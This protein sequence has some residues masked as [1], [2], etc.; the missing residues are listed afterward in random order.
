MYS[1]LRLFEPKCPVTHG[2]L[3]YL[4]AISLLTRFWNY[5]WAIIIYYL[6]NWCSYFMGPFPYYWGFLLTGHCQIMHFL[7]KSLPSF[8]KYFKSLLP[9]ES[10]SNLIS[11]PLIDIWF[12]SALLL[13]KRTLL[14][15]FTYTHTHLLSHKCP[16]FCF[17]VVQL[18]Y[19]R[20]CVCLALAN[21]VSFVKTDIPIVCPP[22]LYEISL[23]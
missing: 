21:I 10:I 20:L 14:W 15:T 8:W 4:W 1:W 18:L 13:L 2:L 11:I 17:P 5:T 23:L 22:Y 7:S 19:H 16:H 3:R 9:T 12:V 6:Q